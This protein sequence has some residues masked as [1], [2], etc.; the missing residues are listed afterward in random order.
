VKNSGDDGKRAA[1]FDF[2]CGFALRVNTKIMFA[3]SI[4]RG[5]LIVLLR[6]NR[7]EPGVMGM[8]G[9]GRT[10]QGACCSRKDR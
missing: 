5:N 9:L 6:K 1:A 3:N 2:L 10:L 8:D 7:G 4:H